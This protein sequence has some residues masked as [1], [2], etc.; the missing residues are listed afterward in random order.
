MMAVMLGRFAVVAAG[1]FVTFSGFDVMF[2]G[3]MF[4]RHVRFL[5]SK[6]CPRRAGRQHDQDGSVSESRQRQ[7][8]GFAPRSAPVMSLS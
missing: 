6:L 5:R 1:M 8:G 7:Q 3:R 4:G 2:A